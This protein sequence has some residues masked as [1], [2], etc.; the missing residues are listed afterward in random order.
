MNFSL[1]VVS[2]KEIA[3]SRTME[4]TELQPNYEFVDNLNFEEMID[5]EDQ[6]LPPEPKPKSAIEIYQN[7][8]EMVDIKPQIKEEPEPLEEMEGN[9]DNL[10]QKEKEEFGM[11]KCYVV[12]CR[13]AKLKSDI[14]L[15]KAQKQLHCNNCESGH[16][17]IFDGKV[18]IEKELVPSQ[19]EKKIIDLYH[20]F[21]RENSRFQISNPDSQKRLQKLRKI[22]EKHQLGDDQKELL[23]VSRS[24]F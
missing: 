12:M 15:H 1:Q 14:S 2:E 3:V 9:I 5:M 8:I 23:K 24:V 16:K 6:V 17:Y 18:Q 19:L 21:D 4:N 10:F 13:N 22:L 11:K 7:L 20:E